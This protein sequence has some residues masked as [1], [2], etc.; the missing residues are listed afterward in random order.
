MIA[1]IYIYFFIKLNG[2]SYTVTQTGA[3]YSG[4]IYEPTTEGVRLG[5]TGVTTYS[6]D[7]LKA[8]VEEIVE[9]GT[10]DFLVNY[11]VHLGDT[12]YILS[13]VSFL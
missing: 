2:I 3:P 8:P 1:D 6:I 12:M 10:S 5:D 4:N 9:V 7:I 11:N 13:T